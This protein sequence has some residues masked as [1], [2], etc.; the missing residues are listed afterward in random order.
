MNKMKSSRQ[1]TK[2]KKMQMEDAWT[3][4]ALWTAVFIDK[5]KYKCEM[6]GND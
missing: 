3:S 6:I 5:V 4:C 1:H 2:K